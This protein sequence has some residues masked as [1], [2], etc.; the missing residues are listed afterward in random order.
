MCLYGWFSVVNT[1]MALHIKG[2]P[3]LVLDFV[4]IGDRVK[5]KYNNK[6]SEPGG[7]H[8]VS[9]SISYV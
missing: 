8:S 5:D 1:K 2:K 7:T 9:L 3:S 6:Y 4:K